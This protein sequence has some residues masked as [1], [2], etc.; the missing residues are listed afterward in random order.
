MTFAA[1]WPT[2]IS[3]CTLPSVNW[4]LGG[5]GLCRACGQN[6]HHGNDE[7]LVCCLHAGSPLGLFEGREYS[8]PSALSPVR[9]ANGSVH[10]SPFMRLSFRA[11]RERA[12]VW[13]RKLGYS[14]LGGA[15]PLVD[16]GSCPTGRDPAGHLA[17]ALVVPLI[18]DE[19]ECLILHQGE[20]RVLPA[21]LACARRGRQE[22]WCA[23]TR[24]VA[25]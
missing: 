19:G 3:P 14:S 17:R 13:S 8:G 7:R 5:G 25:V 15:D 4:S 20:H 6:E 16:P 2:L 1:L 10:R 22:P 24:G 23:A 11:G 18:R 12:V 21:A 9:L